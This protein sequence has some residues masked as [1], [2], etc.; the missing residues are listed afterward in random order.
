MVVLTHTHSLLN[1]FLPH[2]SRQLQYRI[3]A[4]CLTLSLLLF[5]VYCHHHVSSY[6]TETKLHTFSTT[7]MDAD[8]TLRAS[9]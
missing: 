2:N 6:F 9:R 1:L 4:L 8:I 7:Q 5:C 3:L